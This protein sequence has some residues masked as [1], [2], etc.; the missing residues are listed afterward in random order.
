GAR[1]GHAGFQVEQH[2]CDVVAIGDIGLDHPDLSSAALKSRDRVPLALGR[3]TSA[4][5]EH[6]VP[7]ALLHEPV[8]DDEAQCTDSSGDE[9]GGV[10]AEPDLA[11]TSTARRNEA[12][13][14]ALASAD[15]HL[16][17]TVGL[18]DFVP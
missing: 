16:A 12:G 13:N 1:G 11:G 10:G 14:K 2:S 18:A 8:G 15:R 3:G 6:E 4:T 5:A 7:R 17:F 9:I